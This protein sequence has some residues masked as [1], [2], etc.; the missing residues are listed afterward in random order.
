MTE[1]EIGFVILTL[2]I[3]LGAM[4]VFGRAASKLHQPRLVGEILAGALLG[5]FVLGK[6]APQQYDFLFA[7]PTLGADKTK[8]ILGF[9]YWLG[10]LLLMFL[11]GSQV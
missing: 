5:P 7:N 4:H 6:V 3:F 11:S 8:I 2:G 9:V 1:P 10:V